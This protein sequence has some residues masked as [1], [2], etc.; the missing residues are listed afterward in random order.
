M[1]VKTAVM[2]LLLMYVTPIAFARLPNSSQV[3]HPASELVLK[4]NVLAKRLLHLIELNSTIRWSATAELIQEQKG[5]TNFVAMVEKG[6]I[7]TLEELEIT[8]AQLEKSGLEGINSRGIIKIRSLHQE[9]A[10]QGIEAA[11]SEGTVL[12]I[13][14]DVPVEIA[15]AV[16][17]HVYYLEDAMQASGVEGIYAAVAE[18]V[19]YF[20][21][22]SEAD[23]HVAEQTGKIVLEFLHRYVPSAE[24]EVV[25]KE[26]SAVDEKT[27]D[28]VLQQAIE[29]QR[30]LLSQ[31]GVSEEV[32]N[33]VSEALGNLE[34]L[35]AKQEEALAQ[36][37]NKMQEEGVSWEALAH[38]GSAGINSRF[39]V[40]PMLVSVEVS[41]AK[42][43]E[44]LLAGLAEDDEQAR[45]VL[46]QY[47][48]GQRTLSDSELQ[49][50]CLYSICN[51]GVRPML[52]VERV[53][54]EYRRLARQADEAISA[55]L[56]ED[57]R[58]VLATALDV[59]QQTR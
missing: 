7:P 49:Q 25:V 44:Q 45:T 4:D 58:A 21:D 1:Q 9:A 10:Q 41:D 20:E 14:E 22:A 18:S 48:K 31:G 15:E 52:A 24:E 55:V 27:E 38:Y 6:Y 19:T 5:I 34:Q 13:V 33:I 29:Q 35:R 59:Y 32:A 12:E 47:L 2:A 51:I 56:N 30:A 40:A 53:L 50:I 54:D 39:I 16:H 11:I 26:M 36:L 42:L 8:I 46:K 3:V 43:Y 57:R 28:G 17:L 23:K 37:D